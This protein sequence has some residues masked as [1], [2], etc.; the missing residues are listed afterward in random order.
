MYIRIHQVSHTGCFVVSAQT[1]PC[2]VTQYH[3]FLFLHFWGPNSKLSVQLTAARR[4]RRV[5]HASCTQVQF[6]THRSQPHHVPRKSYASE[7][8]SGKGLRWHRCKEHFSFDEQLPQNTDQREGLPLATEVVRSAIYGRQ[9]CRTFWRPLHNNFKIRTKRRVS[10][11]CNLIT[12]SLFHTETSCCVPI[13]RGPS[14][15]LSKKQRAISVQ[16]SIQ[17]GF[18]S[19]ISRRLSHVL[20]SR[21]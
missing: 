5:W 2:P 18:P 20:K 21:R 14:V 16:D 15:P 7:E 19:F 17:H 8:V 1:A 9:L 3:T 11:P 12:H 10:Q 4:H 13:V 6:A